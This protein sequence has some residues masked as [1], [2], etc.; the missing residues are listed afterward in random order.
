MYL[1]HALCPFLQRDA[2]DIDVLGNNEPQVDEMA[3]EIEYDKEKYAF[4]L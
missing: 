1:L 2:E 4:L 3:G